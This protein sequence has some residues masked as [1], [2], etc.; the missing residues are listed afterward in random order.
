[1]GVLLAQ[2]CPKVHLALGLAIPHDFRRAFFVAPGD[3][4]IR[5]VPAE[6]RVYEPTLALN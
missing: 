5:A 1:M 3:D 6:F 2:L 4:V